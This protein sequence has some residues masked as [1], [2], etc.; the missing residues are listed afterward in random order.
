M[1]GYWM[2]GSKTRRRRT[3]LVE[4]SVWLTHA[5]GWRSLSA[6]LVLCAL[7]LAGAIGGCS[8][9]PS[10]QVQTPAPSQSPAQSAAQAQRLQAARNA[11]TAVMADIEVCESTVK[12][13]PTL[14]DL[15]RKATHARDSVQAFSR[16]EDAKLLPKATAALAQAAQ[17]YYDSCA[18]WRADNAAAQASWNKKKTVPIET[19][20]HPSRYEDMWVQG[21]LDLGKVRMA[22]VDANP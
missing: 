7:L 1:A 16:T 9:A 8:K 19:F 3:R 18:V 13:A 21:G 4:R 2:Q 15:T 6:A 14:D 10:K 17:D 5:R 11:A 22:L 12:A 20:Q